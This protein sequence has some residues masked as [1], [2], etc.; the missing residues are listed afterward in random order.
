MANRIP[1]FENL[2]R[3]LENQAPARPT[4][5]EFFLNGRLY[6]GLA[7]RPPPPPEAGL[8]ETY[9]FLAAAFKAA[10]YDYASVNASGFHFPRPERERLSSMSLDE[11][12]L[13]RDRAD[14]DA[15][16]WNEPEDFDTDALAQ[17]DKDLPD[18]MR[19]IVHSPGGVLENAV[20]ICGYQGL[21]Y[22]LAD[23]PE[24]VTEIFAAVGAR[25]ERYYTL[26]AHYPSVG[27]CMVNDDWG[28]KTQTMLRTEDMRR[29]VIPWHKRIVQRIHEAGKPALLH[30]CGNLEAVMD[31]IIDEI[32]FEAKHSFEDAIM[33]VE[34][35]YELHGDRIALLGGI[36]VD[37]VIRASEAEIRKRVTGMLERSSRGGYA[38]GSG[39]SIPE[40][41]PDEKYFAMTSVFLENG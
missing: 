33:P 15:F 10:G 7:G 18:G 20:A 11:N 21:C 12:V 5:Y 30:S 9:L 6:T 23:D 3:V 27:A 37:F 25:L 17:V 39:N 41:V 2:K 38:L 8:R 16:V 36:D 34:E 32:G 13:I 40:Y 29:H 31:D 22:L 4:L 28:F 14:F 24:L 26:A 35:A 19:L 1:D